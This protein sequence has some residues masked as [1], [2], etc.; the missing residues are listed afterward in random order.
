MIAL[1]R[2]IPYSI[3]KREALKRRIPDHSEELPN[4]MEHLRMEWAGY[5][6]EKSL[7]YPLGLLDEDKY[8]IFHGLRI[9]EK[10]YTFQLDTYLLSENFSVILDSKNWGGEVFFKLNPKQVQRSVNGTIVPM[11]NPIEQTKNQQYNLKRWLAENKLSPV[12]IEGYG[13]FNQ[14]TIVTIDKGYYEADKYI[15]KS[16]S[17]LSVIRKLETIYK[18]PVLT[19]KELLRIKKRLLAK[20]TPLQKN[21]LETYHME[22]GSLKKGVFCPQCDYLGTIYK[23]GE[24]H[25][26]SCSHK[27]KDAHLH[28]LEDY[29]LLIGPSITNKQLREFLNLPSISVATKLLVSLKLKKT[30][31]NRTTVYMLPDFGLTS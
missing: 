27:S 28:A 19:P 30:G 25:C 4:L 15:H 18:T 17:L 10:S 23:W 3:R 12:P 26:P 29:Y 11:Q 1:P 5:H 6:G 9:E 20:N 21:I 24:W 2:V 8:H 13:I 22:A 14:N 7:D 16:D 31:K